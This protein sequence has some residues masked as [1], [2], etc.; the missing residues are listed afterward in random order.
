[1]LFSVRSSDLGAFLPFFFSHLIGLLGLQNILSLIKFLQAL[2][3]VIQCL[4]APKEESA[5]QTLT[6]FVIFVVA[7]LHQ[8]NKKYLLVCQ[9]SI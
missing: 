5:N 1:M 7:L 4:P 6:A 8:S 3:A 2:Q 9:K